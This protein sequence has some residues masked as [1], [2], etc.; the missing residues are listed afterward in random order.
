MSDRHSI[1]LATGVGVRRIVIRNNQYVAQT[2]Y[3]ISAALA[4]AGVATTMSSPA[5]RRLVCAAA[6]TVAALIVALSIRVEVFGDLSRLTGA[7]H[8][9]TIAAV[10]LT[11]MVR[12]TLRTCI[13]MPLATGTR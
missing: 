13:A 3:P 6:V 7:I 2:R 12:W 8:G 11:L 5:Q 10:G 1:D 9:L 4:I